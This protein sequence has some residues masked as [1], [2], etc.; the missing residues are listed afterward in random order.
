MAHPRDVTDLPPSDAVP[1]SGGRLCWLAAYVGASFFA[2][3]QL[4]MG[5]VVDLG[6]VLAWLAPACFILGLRGLAPRRALGIGGLAGLVAHSAILH[7]IYVVTVTHGHAPIIVGLLAPVCLAVCIAIFTAAFGAGFAWLEVRGAAHPLSIAVLWTA[8]DH[9]RGFLF[10]GFPWATLGYAQHEN[11]ALMGVVAYTGVYGLSFVS[12]LGAAALARAGLD[13]WRGVRPGAAV[14][15]SAVIVLLAHALG[16]ATLTRVDE[17][18]LPHVRMAVIQGNIEQDVKWSPEWRGR[19]LTA[20]SDLPRRAAREGAKVVIWP[21][22]AV[23]GGVEPYRETG[24]LVMALARETATTLV[25]GGVGLRYDGTGRVSEFFDS[26][27]LVD[28]DGRILE[29]YDK[30]HLVPFGEYVPFRGLLGRFLSAVASGIASG[31]V[32]PG[33][34]P[35]ALTVPFGPTPPDADSRGLR[36]G[37]PICYELLFPA[38]VRRFV[39][40]GAQVL[41]AITNDAWYG[42]TGAPFQFLAM[43]AMRSAENRVWTARAANTGVTAFIDARGRVH[44]RTEIFERDLLVLDVP[45]RAAPAGG[46][47]YSRHG[48]VFAGVCWLAAI[49]IVGLALRNGRPARRRTKLERN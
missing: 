46:S 16:F 41:L 6:V 32:T 40:D 3:P 11:L 47:F 44:S 29:R 8:L 1:T 43:T 22:S 5:E 35:R 42:R 19:T 25:I 27:F 9:M 26:A 31:D 24:K 17:S 21:E 15:S 13:L 4:V 30:S 28:R 20:Y 12:A 34:G 2:F 45:L 7:W 36:A 39:Y 14:W 10:T 49:A 48:D 37:V 33:A 38:L 23:P 18:A